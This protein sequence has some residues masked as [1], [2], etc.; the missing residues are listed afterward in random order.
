MFSN[1]SIVMKRVNKMTEYNQLIKKKARRNL[2]FTLKLASTMKP[3]PN[4][5]LKCK[6]HLKEVL[7][8]KTKPLP[9]EIP[10]PI[11]SLLL[12]KNKDLILTEVNLK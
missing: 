12:N 5:A 7:K 2:K 3:H 1:K 9:K 8:I 6:D 10:K 4:K 11:K